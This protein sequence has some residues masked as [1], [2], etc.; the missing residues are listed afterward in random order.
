MFVCVFLSIYSVFIYMY[1]CIYLRVYMCG[2]ACLFGRMTIQE[3]LFYQIRGDMVLKIKEKGKPKDVV[4]K[5]GEMF[6]LPP[7]IPHSPQRRKGWRH[8]YIVCSSFTLLCCPSTSV[9]FYV[10]IHIRLCQYLYLRFCPSWY[11]A[12]ASVGN[13]VIDDIFLFRFYSYY[14]LLMCRYYWPCHREGAQRRRNG[15]HAMVRSISILL[16]FVHIRACS[17]QHLFFD[18]PL[19]ITPNAS[20]YT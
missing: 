5:E 9:Y 20:M 18:F 1:V 11:S 10:S 17:H 8:R 3:E 16:S 15:L 19:K 4:I 14:L 2:W 12:S 7:R 13:T 6:L